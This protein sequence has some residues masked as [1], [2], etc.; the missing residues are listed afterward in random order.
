VGALISL[1]GLASG[2]A[3]ADAEAN[4]S[5][6]GL[7]PG[8]YTITPSKNG[9]TFRP[10]S[11]TVTL[12][13]SSVAAV[14]F[15]ASAVP[16]YSISGT[17]TPI[18]I[19]AGTLVTLSPYGYAVANRYGNFTFSN[20]PPATYTLS[21]ARTGYTFSP[22][23]L[24]IALNGAPSTGNNFSGTALTPLRLRYPDL[25]DIIPPSKM[26]IA[27]TGSSR[28]FQ[29]T[30]DTFEGGNGPLEIQ[31]VYNS[32]SGNYQG[33]QHIYSFNNGTWT[34]SQSIPVA[35]AFVFDSAH[36]HFHFPFVTYGL[37]YSNPD[38]SI[39]GLV[40]P[41]VKDGFCIDNS[42]IYDSL[43]PN[44][45]FGTW[46]PCSDPTSLRGLSIGA[47]DEYDQTDEGQAI[48]I[49]NLPDGIY[50]LRALVDPN[51][52][53]A[54]SDKTNN[55]TDVQMQFTGN[56]I[57]VLQIYKPVLPPP[58]AV[59][60]V[61][62]NGGTQVSGTIQL[63]ATTASQGGSGMQFLIDGLPFGG[64]VTNSP[65]ILNWDTTQVH[66]G[67]HW[68][69]AQYTDSTGRIGTSAVA[70]VSV[71]NPSTPAPIVTV[72]APSAGSTV[73]AVTTLDATV[74]STNPI[75]SVQFLADGASVGTPLTKPPYNTFWDTET[76]SMGAHTVTAT[77]TDNQ[78]NIGNSAPVSVS[79]NNT[80]PP[81]VIGID[82]Q[83]YRD[84]TGIMTSP[85][86]S[87]T[88]NSDLLVAFVA[89]DGPTS[90]GQTATVSG[91]GLNWA[92]LER[93][94]TQ[95]GDA[96]I[97]AAKASDFLSNATVIMQPTLGS[98]YHGTLVVIAFSN[99]VGPGIVGR[100]AAPSG[101]PDI[102]LPGVSAG[103]WVFAVGNDWDNP[104][105]RTPVSHQY[106]VHQRVD[107]TVGDTSWVQATIAPSTANSLIDIHDSSPTSDQWN[108]CAVEVVATRQ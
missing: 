91:A 88:T 43:L 27:G 89:L 29:Y 14:N 82:A 10:G 85:V 2:T 9:Y 26:S 102:Y 5:F 96:E 71:R 52:Y 97:W 3:T 40:A 32:A 55:E 51:N 1:S 15:T 50:W 42:F 79:V 94:N 72:T 16:S 13:S 31:P 24:T 54:E 99:A 45:G 101:P 74:A 48:T 35:G 81:N 92:L 53:L 41:S 69:A 68:V 38:G 64:V 63:S 23:Q 49:G 103:N 73:N 107:T 84:G 47:V 58:P 11:A 100:S 37:Y 56:K 95:L 77:A 33:F 36:G 39:G 28:V 25:K 6:T 98:S 104:I 21:V 105:T 70:S 108:Y 22:A 12:T 65:Y 17:I 106:L 83:V 76:Y 44:A 20:L 30:H 61:T 59:T 80:N 34:V 93:S 78:G 57:T 60:L 7:K 87:T 86:F 66:N 75:S 46:G 90:G 67:N 62:P 18:S 8:T 19:G 4:Y